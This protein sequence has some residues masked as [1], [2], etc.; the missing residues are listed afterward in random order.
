M[1]TEPKDTK[2]RKPRAPRRN[3]AEERARLVMHCK[4]S[5]GILSSRPQL[6]YI[7]YKGEH[8]PFPGPGSSY[9]DGQIAALKAVLKF[10][11]ETE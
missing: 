2:P 3:F 9:D 6:P 4:L 7:E 10:M 1:A 11:G 5:I 8:P